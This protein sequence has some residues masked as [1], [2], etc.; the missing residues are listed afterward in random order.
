M[1]L[2]G[3]DSR[4][5]NHMNAAFSKLFQYINDF[6]VKNSVISMTV[7]LRHA[8]LFQNVRT[9]TSKKQFRKTEFNYNVLWKIS[10]DVKEEVIGRG[11]EP[12]AYFKIFKLRRIRWAERTPR[13]R[14]ENCV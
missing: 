9:V 7:G 14:G 4:N 5:A 10:R 2:H 12:I 8:V 3:T 13:T 1:E 11:L 6:N